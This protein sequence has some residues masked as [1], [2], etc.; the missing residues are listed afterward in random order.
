VR[1]KIGAK[2]ASGDE[3]KTSVITTIIQFL[4]FAKHFN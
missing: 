2:S 3:A 4:H 1:L